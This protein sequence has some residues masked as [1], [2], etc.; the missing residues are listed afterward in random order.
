MNRE[1]ALL[2]L[3]FYTSA[4]LKNDVVPLEFENSGKEKLFLESDNVIV[5]PESEENLIEEP[6]NVD[7][8][9]E[10]FDP[11]EERFPT[12][13]NGMKHKIVKRYHCSVD[14]HGFMQNNGS[15]CLHFL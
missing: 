2:F 7:S 12:W 9:E 1:C 11:S 10:Y 3:L 5:L 15:F 4:C 14:G 6:H 8:S 13:M